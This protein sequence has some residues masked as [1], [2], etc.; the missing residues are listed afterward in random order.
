MDVALELVASEQGDGPC[1]GHTKGEEE[2]DGNDIASGEHSR[3]D[4]QNGKARKGK[5][6]AERAVVL[7][8]HE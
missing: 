3:D 5:D 1:N 8:F 7:C 2:D 6:R 4:C